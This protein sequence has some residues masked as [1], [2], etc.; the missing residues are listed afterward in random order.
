MHF[1]SESIRS[2]I[3]PCLRDAVRQGL[4]FLLHFIC[5]KQVSR[6]SESGPWKEPL[7]RELSS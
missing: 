3:V 2:G 4:S 1:R 6:K 5:K 7:F